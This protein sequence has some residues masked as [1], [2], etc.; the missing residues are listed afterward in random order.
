[1]IRLGMMRKSTGDW[2]VSNEFFAVLAAASLL[3]GGCAEH[4][5][6]NY[7]RF[8]PFSEVES[9]SKP[10]TGNPSIPE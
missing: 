1:M 2:N 9:E 3:V 6:G 4:R 7:Q 10:E 8:V 5:A